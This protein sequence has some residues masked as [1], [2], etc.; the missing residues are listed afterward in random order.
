MPLRYGW[1]PWQPWKSGGYGWRHIERK[2]KGDLTFAQLA[3]TLRTGTLRYNSK[4]GNYEYRKTFSGRRC[5]CGTTH[6][7]HAVVVVDYRSLSTAY[8]DRPV[9]KRGIVT[10]YDENHGWLSR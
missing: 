6:K 9:G 2:H 7:I 1:A 8:G 4:S 3:E 10:A 5:W